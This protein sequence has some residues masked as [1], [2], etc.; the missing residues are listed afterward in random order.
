MTTAL[1]ITDSLLANFP[2]W[3]V[4]G[5][6]D[7]AVR[8]ALNALDLSPVVNWYDPDEIPEPVVAA[9]MDF[10]GVAGLDTT[11]FGLDFRRRILAANT[12]LRRFPRD[13]VRAAGIQPGDRRGLHLRDR[14]ATPTPATPTA[15][16]SRSPRP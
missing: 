2:Y 7:F 5:G 3:K 11:I 6:V 9:I 13:G 8:E 14:A 1:R 12:A 4:T 10:Y 16:C 15:S